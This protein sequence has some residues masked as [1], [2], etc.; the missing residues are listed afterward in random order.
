MEQQ[1]QRMFELTREEVEASSVE[2]LL[3]GIARE[4]EARGGVSHVQG[5]ICFFISGYEN[6]PRELYEIPEVR[7]YFHKLD[8]LAPFFL[9]FIASESQGALI[10]LFVKMFLNDGNFFA[11]GDSTAEDKHLF[12]SFL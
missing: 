10:R 8:A 4:G 11:N 2:R 6:D 7:N 9:F 3:L 12:V 5:K 1:L